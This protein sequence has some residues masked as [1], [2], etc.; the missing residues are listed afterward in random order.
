MEWHSNAL[1]SV[2]S[3]A[4]CWAGDVTFYTDPAARRWGIG[5][6]LY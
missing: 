4:Y 5:R 3:E 2:I 1:D 6:A